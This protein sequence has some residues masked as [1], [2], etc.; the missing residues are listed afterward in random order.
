MISNKKTHPQTVLPTPSDRPYHI[1]AETLT[2]II[3]YKLVQSQVNPGVSAIFPVKI[4][5]IIQLHKEILMRSIISSTEMIEEFL[6]GTEK[7]MLVMDCK[8]YLLFAWKSII[9]LMKWILGG[10]S[11]ECAKGCEA[12]IF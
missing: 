6:C 8:A 9:D 7:S 2:C 1:S 4:F 10:G 12:K 11:I 5:G 3:A